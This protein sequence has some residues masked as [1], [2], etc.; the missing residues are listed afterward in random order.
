MRSDRSDA[1]GTGY[2]SVITEAY[3]PDLL[4]RA[5]GRPLE[6]PAVLGPAAAAGQTVGGS[7]LGPG[8][9]DNA[10]AAFGVGAEPG[11]VVVVDRHLGC[12]ERGGRNPGP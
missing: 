5:F 2:W 10:A 7:L 3:R 11:D 12:G 9:G 8:A 4:E 1:S 6:V